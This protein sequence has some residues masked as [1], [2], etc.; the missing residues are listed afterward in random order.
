LSTNSTTLER[1]RLVLG[2]FGK[3]RLPGAQSDQHRRMEAA[4]DYLYSREYRGRG[5]REG[6]GAAQTGGDEASQFTIPTWLSEVRELF[7]RETSEIIEKHALDRYELT[8]LVTDAETL[9]KLQPNMELLK[10]LLSFRG[11]LKGEVLDQARRIIRHVVEEIR[12]R[13]ETE[14][15]QALSGRLNRFRHSPLKAA[16]NF[17]WRTTLRRNLKHYDPQL[18]AVVLHEQ[19]FFARDTRHL[20]WDVILCVDQSGSM[21][22]SLIHSAVMAGIFASLPS[23]RVKL[24]AFDTSVVDLTEHA[25]D[26]VEVLMSV[27]LGGGTDI[28]GA[29]GYCETLIE[30]PRR[31][32]FVLVSDFIEGG[33]ASNLL[34]T[35]KRLKEAGVTLLG[36]A[37]LNADALPV[38][39]P[40]MAQRLADAGMDVAALTPKQLAGWLARITALK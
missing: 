6:D 30:Q 28:A 19:K 39:D 2:R 40:Q 21:A 23:L 32:V 3:S 7:P 8:E 37:A 20:P 13:W 33:S 15:R 26:P 29:L 34:A 10:T 38:H 14:V 12:K 27:Q 11:H 36:L 18:R 16:Q 25:A 4:L 22:E 35:V 31:T 9:A 5:L 17:D 24:V 1:W